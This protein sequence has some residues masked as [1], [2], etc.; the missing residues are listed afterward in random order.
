MWGGLSSGQVVLHSCA[1]L[2]NN[3]R[4]R[5]GPQQEQGCSCAY[6]IH[7]TL[8]NMS[9]QSICSETSCRV[10][11]ARARTDATHAHQSSAHLELKVHINGAEEA[12]GP[13]RAHSILC[14]AGLACGLHQDQIRT[15]CHGESMG[16][17]HYCLKFLLTR[18]QVQSTWC[19]QIQRSQHALMRLVTRS[20]WG[21]STSDL[22]VPV[23]QG[24]EP[25]RESCWRPC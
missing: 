4:Q 24:S 13:T 17:R 12:S 16:S 6:D 19:S 3:C 8:L 7:V 14:Y 22:I 15:C 20:A 1:L 5:L 21:E 23:F 2:V 18:L 9:L 25:A 11:L 10:Y